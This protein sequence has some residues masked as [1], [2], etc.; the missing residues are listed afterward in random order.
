MKPK[1]KCPRQDP[2]L[3]SLICY[4]NCVSS[5]WTV[6]NPDYWQKSISDRSITLSFYVHPS[7]WW[8]TPPCV[9]V[10]FETMVLLIARLRTFCFLDVGRK[11]K[12]FDKLEVQFREAQSDAFIFCF[13][14]STFYCSMS[15]FTEVNSLKQILHST[16]NSEWVVTMDHKLSFC[17]LRSSL[18]FRMP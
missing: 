11:T 4:I 1:C 18:N 15:L 3:Y 12:L 6:S 14:N 17:R 9:A 8:V 13:Q 5:A 2:C 7:L 10:S 16:M